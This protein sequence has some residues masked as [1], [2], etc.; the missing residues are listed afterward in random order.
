MRDIIAIIKKEM[1]RFFSDKRMVLSSVI[2]PGILIYIVY[3]IMGGALMK[4]ETVDKSYTPIVYVVNSTDETSALLEMLDYDIRYISEDGV[5]G[6][7]TAKSDII[8]K[9]ADCLVY[10]PKNFTISLANL[11][12][13]APN[14]GVYFNSTSPDSV[15]AYTVITNAL[16]T[17]ES[18][19]VNLFDIN[20]DDNVAYD[21]AT[22]ED[23]SSKV[24]SS[25]LPMILIMLLFSGCIAFAPD[26]FAGEKDRGTIATLLVTPLNRN[27]LAIGKVVSLSVF[28]LLNGLSSFIG[29][30]LAIP[31]MF[32]D[33][34]EVST[35]IY[36]IKEYA[37]LLLV[38]SSSVIFIISI[39]SII[40]A[41]SKTAKE[42]SSMCSPLM[43]GA[44]LLGTITNMQFDMSAPAWRLIPVL[45]SILCIDDVLKLN[46][47][48]MNIVITCISNLFFAVILIYVLTRLLNSEKIV[49]S[50]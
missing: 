27:S 23:T 25:I 6:I 47:V 2:L 39:L 48:P 13:E 29:T 19:I 1:Y 41:V 8:N 42:A 12:T 44:T 17:F 14:V 43:M 15:N 31:K 33:T 10:F 26:A 21:L 4:T 7:D 35:S 50:K 16:N 5:T 32:G 20:I 9:K 30:V 36:G 37:Y 40:S 18:S 28:A 22:A 24:W 49:F 34:V 38:I 11:Q 3:S 46:I 45:N